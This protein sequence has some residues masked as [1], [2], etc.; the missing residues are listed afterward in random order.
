MNVRELLEEWGCDYLKEG[1]EY[2]FDGPLD[3]REI[4]QLISC[5]DF[6]LLIKSDEDEWEFRIEI[7]V[8]KD[9]RT[10]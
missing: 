1:H 3:K 8:D 7:Q 6:S 9:E 5:K 10:I 4:K 2:Y